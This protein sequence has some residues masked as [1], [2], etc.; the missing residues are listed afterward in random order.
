MKKVIELKELKEIQRYVSSIFLCGSGVGFFA[1]LILN[2]GFHYTLRNI[3]D[4]TFNRH[5]FKGDPPYFDVIIGFFVSNIKTLKRMDS[6]EF[7]FYVICAFVGV[8]FFLWGLY[9]FGIKSLILDGNKVYVEKKLF[10][11]FVIRRKGLGEISNYETIQL[12]NE[13]QTGGAMVGNT[14]VPSTHKVFSLYFRGPGKIEKAASFHDFKI[15]VL[16][17]EEVS[18]ATGLKLIEQENKANA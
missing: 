3:Y 6:E 4:F 13:L 8:I 11:R 7:W 15:G 14:Y 9:Y 5:L 17:A 2:G 16:C 1:P 10:N 12:V 18:K